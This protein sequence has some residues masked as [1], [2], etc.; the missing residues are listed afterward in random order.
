[1]TK[2]LK[3][4]L[5]IGLFFAP[6]LS[7]LSGFAQSYPT[8]PIKI[9]VPYGAGS[10]TDILARKIAF[11]LG[12]VLG[13]SVFV[14]NKAGANAVIGASYAAHAN[15]DGYTI[16][17]GNTQTNAV[18]P[19]LVPNLSYDALKDFTPVA[20]LFY[21]G[22]ILVVSSKLPVNNLEELLAYVKSN[23]KH[24]NF[25]STA[26]GNVSHLPSAYLSK[27]A[28]IPMTHIPYNNA[29]QLMTDL[30]RGEVTMLFYPPEGVKSF[31]D[32]GIMKPLAWSGETRNPQ[33]PNIPTMIELGYKNFN[34][35]AWYA[36][37]A[38][39]GTSNAVIQK[40]YDSIN[41]V[42]HDPK[43]IQDMSN[44]STNL[45]LGD[46]KETDAFVNQEQN[47][48]KLITSIIDKE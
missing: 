13:Q 33:F 23:P 12:V 4:S 3:L 48:F 31:I 39:T 15:P 42:F 26:Y 28:S 46:P 5:R 43:F 14:E 34:I 19:Q 6:L 1:M 16:L 41:K 47:K 30:A 38:P 20:R 17:F 7:S 45:F 29:G 8:Q 22:T 11:P 2:Y 40:L 18:N 25:G 37:F 24:A 10:A 32:S 21:S 9:V 27:L 44:G 36:L 35:G